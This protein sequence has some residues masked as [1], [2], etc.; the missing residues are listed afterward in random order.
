MAPS[1][2]DILVL[3]LG[4]C[5]LLLMVF[6]RQA[7]KAVDEKGYTI[8]V[9]SLGCFT[10]LAGSLLGLSV[11]IDCLWFGAPCWGH[12]ITGFLAGGV[13]GAWLAARWTKKWDRELEAEGHL[14]PE[15]QR[16]WQSSPFVLSLTLILLLIAVFFPHG[17]ARLF[18]KTEYLWAGIS[19]AMCGCFVVSGLLIAFWGKEKE[20]QGFKPFVIHMRGHKQP[21]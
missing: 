14:L 12:V 3:A 17:L 11:I 19:F 18:S 10:A 1:W 16:W 2:Y 7:R 4:L 15:I 13:P 8:R 20:R 6:I 9:V 5:G 21:R